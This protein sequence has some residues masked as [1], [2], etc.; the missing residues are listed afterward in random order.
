MVESTDESVLDRNNGR[1]CVTPDFPNGTYAYFTTFDSTAAADGVFKNF[2][3]PTF[4]YV[5][6][7]YFKAQPNAF[8]YDINSNQDNYDIN[9]TSFRRNTAPYSIT[10]KNSGYDY[11]QKS[12][13]F[14]DQDSVI[15]TTEKGYITEVGIVTSGSNYKINDRVVF[16]SEKDFSLL[17]EFQDWMAYQ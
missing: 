2:K 1:F 7:E 5:I 4:P 13:D 6:G 15:T 8:N 11:L 3:K 9:V 17:L 12:Y 14:V 16:E 10:K